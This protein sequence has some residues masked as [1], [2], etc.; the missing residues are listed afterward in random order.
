MGPEAINTLAGK[1]TGCKLPV[2]LVLY[3]LALLSVLPRLFVLA[4]PSVL[5]LVSVL[6][7]LYPFVIPGRAVL[8]QHQ[9]NV[10]GLGDMPTEL[11]LYVPLSKGGCDS[12]CVLSSTQGGYDDVC[13]LF[14]TQGG[15]DAVCVQY[16]IRIAFCRGRW[17]F[18]HDMSG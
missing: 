5:A 2:D 14:S 17:P 6:A 9:C 16:R 3:V 11:F 7:L 8:D 12:V 1:K 4:V 10:D 13:I 18:Q 15:F